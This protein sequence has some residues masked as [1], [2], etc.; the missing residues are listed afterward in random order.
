M[1]N[2]RQFKRFER[3]C[4]IEFAANGILYTGTTD[5]LSLN[6]LFIRTDLKFELYTTLEMVIHLS[7]GK[8][9]RLKGRVMRITKDGTG[10]EIIEKDTTY[11]HYYSRCIVNS[12]T[13]R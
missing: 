12:D 4:E 1:R 6:G 7:D 10:V 9:S 5:D 2:K 8:T 3:R 13:E 11:L